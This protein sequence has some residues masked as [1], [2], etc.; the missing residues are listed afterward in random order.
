MKIGPFQIGKIAEKLKGFWSSGSYTGKKPQKY[1]P[2]LFPWRERC[3]HY[4]KLLESNAYAKSCAW[5]LAGRVLE[6]GL[7]LEATDKYD[8]AVEAM[9]RCEQLNTDI[10]MKNLLY[11]TVAQWAAHGSFFW[12][13]TFDPVFDVKAVPNQEMME[14]AHADENGEIDRW[15]LALWGGVANPEWSR[16]EIVHF[17]WMRTSQSYPYG[18]SLFTGCETELEILEQLELDIKEHMHRT[19]FPQTAIGV[20]D[21]KSKPL[22]DEINDIRASIKNWQP[23]EIHATS[24]KLTQANISGDRPIQNLGD[25]LEFC[26]DNVTDSFLI[27]PISKLYNSTYASSKEMQQMENARLIAP[28]QTLIG[29]ILEQEIYKPYL[30]WLGFSVR[31]VPSVEWENPDAEK[32]E[33]A[34]YWLKWVQA[35]I[36]LMYAAEQAGF[37]VD[38]LEA[39]VQKDEAEK[40]KRQQ[41]FAQFQ[42]TQPFQQGSQQ[43]PNQSGEVWEVRKKPSV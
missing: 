43:N 41:E 35:G 25:V 24:Y 6:N 17:C 9:E 15:R 34:D 39:A 1:H 19:A 36:P 16:E 31:V 42:K 32:P 33:I 8:R 40:L 23:G 21:D 3:I 29:H 7:Y 30:E 18:T 4:D 38:K 26:K 37:D 12:E 22:P 28:M 2:G 13:K 14:P 5:S 11:D 27:S 20:G 10:G